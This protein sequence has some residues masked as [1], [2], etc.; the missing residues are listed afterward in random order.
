[1]ASDQ[2]GKLKDYVEDKLSDSDFQAQ[3]APGC[4]LETKTETERRYPPGK[5][6]E[7]WKRTCIRIVSC[8]DPDQNTYW[9][10]KP[11]EFDW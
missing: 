4:E 5:P 10:C 6:I 1:M 11:W 3:L 7:H 9:R 2:D 8:D